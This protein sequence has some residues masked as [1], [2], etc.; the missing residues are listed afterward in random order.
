MGDLRRDN[1]PELGQINELMLCDELSKL[2]IFE[3]CVSGHVHDK[4]SFKSVIT[5]YWKSI[6]AQF[7]DL[8]YLT[9]DSVGYHEVDLRLSE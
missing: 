4:T 7:R 3:T 9:G 1:H 6:K 8:R 2:P 5:S